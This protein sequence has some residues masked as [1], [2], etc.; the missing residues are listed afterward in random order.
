MEIKMEI[1]KE[2]DLDSFIKQKLSS[3]K[4]GKGF[5]L[6]LYKNEILKIL[7]SGLSIAD[8]YE[9][10]TKKYSNLSNMGAPNLYRYIKKIKKAEVG[11]PEP[12]KQLAQVVHVRQI[13]NVTTEKI[14]PLTEATFAQSEPLIVDNRPGRS[15]FKK[16]EPTIKERWNQ[17]RKS[18]DGVPYFPDQTEE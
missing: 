5:N 1:G 6:P 3:N 11:Q 13:E 7:D 16:K 2:L 17:T 18:S 12:K 8:A 15:A 4:K 10:L 9:Y 14:E